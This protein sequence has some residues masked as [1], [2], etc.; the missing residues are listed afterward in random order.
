MLIPPYMSRL[1]KFCFVACPED[2]YC[3]CRERSRTICSPMS[4][5]QTYKPKVQEDDEWDQQDMDS[6]F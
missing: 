3:E 4:I 6:W 5:P 2:V 1:E